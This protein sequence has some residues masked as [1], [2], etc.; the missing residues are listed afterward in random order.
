MLICIIYDTL[1]IGC[2]IDLSDCINMA[3][4]ET[5]EVSRAAALAAQRAESD[6][7][8]RRPDLSD[9]K[10]KQ[11]RQEMYRKQKHEKNKE[12][13]EKR[14][15]RQRETDALGEDVRTLLFCIF[16]ESNLVEIQQE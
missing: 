5:G 1:L 7:A 12:K 8:I 2:F 3:D 6:A 13:R 10:N 14:K 9:I 11:L 16:L 15:K 4:Q